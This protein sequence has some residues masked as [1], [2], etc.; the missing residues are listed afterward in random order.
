MQTWWKVLVLTTAMS[1]CVSSRLL[2][3]RAAQCPQL[4]KRET[5]VPW[6]AAWLGDLSPGPWLHLALSGLQD[7]INTDVVMNA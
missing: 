1:P 3:P 4:H 5:P 6:G 7:C 2:T